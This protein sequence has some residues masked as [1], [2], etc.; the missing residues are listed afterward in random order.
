MRTSVITSTISNVFGINQDSATVVVR[1]ERRSHALPRQ[2]SKRHAYR[3]LANS[4]AAILGGFRA[5][6]MRTFQ[7]CEPAG[8]QSVGAMRGWLLGLPAPLASQGNG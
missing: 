6:A 5:A 3:G 8:S 1:D 7:N 4:K 2:L